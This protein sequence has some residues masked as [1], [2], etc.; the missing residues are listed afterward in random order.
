MFT[1]SNQTDYAM[2]FLE[3]L[4]RQKKSVPLARAVEELKLPRRFMAHVASKLVAAQ[5]L[6]SQEGIR[7]GYVLIKPLKKIKLY[8][9]LRL[10]EGDMKLVKC[11]DDD[12]Q[13]QLDG[14]CRHKNLW[15]G[16]L[17]KKFLTVMNSVSVADMTN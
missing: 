17:Q 12:Y 11:S 8:E 2:L 4:S 3:Y 14:I 13:C 7:G 16:K 6:K 1:I 5:I 10:F 9:L 15:Q